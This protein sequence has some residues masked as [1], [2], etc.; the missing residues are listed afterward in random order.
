MSSGLPGSHPV[1]RMRDVLWPGAR[2][3]ARGL[4]HTP[5]LVLTLNARGALYCVFSHLRQGDDR[6]EVLVPA[7]HC[8]SVVAPL[9]AAGLKPVFY[10]IT[11]DLTVD[12]NDLHGRTGP[13]TRAV[14]VI[15]FFGH[16]TD[17]EPTAT[18]RRDGVAI[19][20]DWSHSFLRADSLGFPGGADSHRVFSLWKLLPTHV[21]GA[22]LPPAHA[23]ASHGTRLATLPFRRQLVM[24]KRLLEDSIEHH[25]PAALARGIERFEH[26]RVSRKLPLAGEAPAAGDREL[27]RNGEV[28]Y[29]FSVSLDAMPMPWWIRRMVAGSDLDCIATTRLRHYEHYA[30]ALDGH[31]LVRL[32]RSTPP[33]AVPWVFPVFVEGRDRHDREWRAMGVPLHTFGIYLHSGLFRDANPRVIA[34]ALYLSDRLLCLAVHQDLNDHDVEHACDVLWQAA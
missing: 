33:H 22:W 24:G 4:L 7:F 18:L 19:I 9:L 21:G 16:A 23:N 30:R 31:P 13:H 6:D 29:P 20:E 27:Q 11:R 17:L 32:W 10:G 25:G 5:G 14:L 28:Y 2:T 3:L 34:D 26:W 1:A 12:W 15:H 8:P